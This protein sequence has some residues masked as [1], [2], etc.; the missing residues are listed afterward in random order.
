MRRPFV[1]MLAVLTLFMGEGVC[2]AGDGAIRKT[3]PCDWRIHPITGHWQYHTGVD[4][5]APQGTNVLAYADGRV[6][7]TGWYKGYGYIIQVVHADGLVT[8]YSHLS[9]FAPGIQDGIPVNKRQILGYVGST[10]M[11]T[12]PHLDFRAWIGRTY[13]NP[14]RL[15]EGDIVPLSGKALKSNGPAGNTVFGGIAEVS[16]QSGAG[17]PD[18]QDPDK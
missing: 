5:G 12:G 15:L 8:Q 1:A 4:Y 10:G 17:G 3:S 11:S 18:D 16:S 2:H 13:I 6:A 14:E 9:G 7:Y